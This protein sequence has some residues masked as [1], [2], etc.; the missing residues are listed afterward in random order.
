MNWESLVRL[1]R[2]KSESA[3]DRREGSLALAV[4]V[5]VGAGIVFMLTTIFGG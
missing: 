3:E 1:V 4:V 2:G 5:G